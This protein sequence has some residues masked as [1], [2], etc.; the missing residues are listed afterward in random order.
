MA[1]FIGDTFERSGNRLERTEARHVA[2]ACRASPFQMGPGGVEPPTSRLSGVRS[3]HLSYEPHKPFEP[4]KLADR[5]IS[6]HQ[7]SFG[8]RSSRPITS[9]AW[10]IC[11][12]IAWP[13]CPRNAVAVGATH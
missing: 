4:K 3:N 13:P 2:I 12:A 7:R 11:S 9:N 5:I 10:D 6:V 1:R 8:F